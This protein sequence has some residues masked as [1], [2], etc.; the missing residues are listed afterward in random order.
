MK[1]ILR[2]IPAILLGFL[3]MANATRAEQYHYKSGTPAVKQMAAGC[4]PGANFK[5]LEIN[6]VRTRINTGGDMWWDFEVAQY[7]VPKGSKKMSMFSAA[8]WIGGL[9]ANGQLKLAALRYRQVGNDYWPG[10]LTI[11]GTAS[12]SPDVCAKYDKL[13]A[14][15]R[16]EVDDFL[17]WFDDKAAHPD[18][19]PPTSITAYPAHGDE[20][21]GQS[22][23]LAPFYDSD[24]TGDP[25]GIY[26]PEN[27]GDYPYYDLSNELCHTKTL[28]A[29]DIY[30]NKEQTGNLVDQVLKG[31]ATLWW[32]FN[33]KG[34]IHSETKGD[35][36][37]LEIRAQAF[38]F[39]TNDEINNMTFYSYEIINRSTYRLTQTYFSQWVDT[40]LG[41]AKDDYVGCD[42]MRGLG[43]CYNGTAVDGSGQSFAYGNQPPAIGVDFFQGPYIDK[44]KDNKLNGDNPSTKGDPT[45]HLKG[46]PDQ[47]FTGGIQLV[48]WDGDTIEKVV[49]PG[50]TIFKVINSAA[51]NGI[52]FGNDIEDD[53]RFGMRRFVYHNNGGAAY[54][55]DPSVAIE[56]YNYLRGIWK[57]GTKMEYGGNGHITA[58]ATGPE[59]DFM[60]PGTTDI[61]DWGTKGLPPNGPKNWTEVTAGNPPDD[62]RFMESAGP[63]VL[64]P[65]AVNYITVGIP[66]A[67][68]LT[69][70]PLASVKLLQQV[71]DK[72]QQ[73][74]DNCFKVI[75]GPNAPDLTI[76]EMD[77]ELILYISNRKTN[78]A[79][80]NFQEKYTEY[81][82]RIQGSETDHWDSLYRFEGYQIYQLKNATVSVADLKNNEQARLVYQCDVKNNVTQLVNYYFDQNL[83]GSVPVEEV[84]GTDKGVIHSVK[85]S[86]DIFTGEDLINHKQYYYLAVAYAHNNY[87]DYKQSDP[88]SLNGQKLPYLAGRKNIKTYTGIPHTAIGLVSA[89]SEYGDGLVVTRT[90]GQGNGGRFLDLSD[91]SIAEIMSKKM[92]DSTNLPGGPD[93]PIAYNLTYKKDLGPI[94]V[95]VIDPLNVKDGSYTVKFDSMYNVRV[96]VGVMDTTMMAASWSLVDNA[97]GK[98]YVSDTSINTQNEQ[99]FL[100]LGLSVVIEQSLY[101]GPYIVDTKIKQQ[102]GSPDQI[103]P[104]YGPVLAKNGY[105]GGSMVYQDS[106]KPWLNFLPDVDGLPNFDWIRAGLRTDVPADWNN[107]KDM[108][109]DPDAVY[110]SVL[111][112]TWTPYMFAETGKND[113]VCGVAHGEVQ[114]EAQSRERCLFTDISGVDI[115]FTAD[116]SKWTRCAVIELCPFPKASFAEGGAKQFEVRKGKSV[117]Q[118]GDTAVVSSDPA[119]NSE[120]IAANGMSWFPGYAI[121]VET[122][123]RLNI[124]FGE[125]SRMVDDNGRD[126]IFNPSSRRMAPGG[127]PV[128]GGKHFI[129]VMGHIANKKKVVAPSS[130][131]P[132]EA[133]DS[134]AYDGCANFVKQVN[135]PR[136]TALMK[137]V[138]G[139]QF[140]NCMWVSIPIA[141]G[142]NAWLN[143]DLKIKLR[144]TKPYGR[145]FSTPLA[146]TQ[147]GNNYWPMYTFET[148]GVVTNYNDV[149]KAE[150]DLDMIN[151][152]PNPYYAYSKYE[153]NQL[154]NRVKI[155][156]LPQRCTVT[157]YSTN[158]NIVRQYNKDEAKTSIDWDLKN[159]AGIPIAGGVYIIHVKSDQGEKVIKWFGSLRPVDLN[160]F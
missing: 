35:P 1:N 102:T 47:L 90:A 12:I 56:Y 86:K 89:Q 96:K 48:L 157:I 113:T 45:F 52:N 108:A 42:V 85:M 139:L 24:A 51:I 49:S 18:Y 95:K 100:D 134:P 57:D 111:G 55:Q 17:A 81:D 117:N 112:G 129:Y 75:S 40:D 63:F 114:V 43:Y 155:V 124:M 76:R 136:L 127:H 116:K 74:F 4:T 2:I 33:D 27:D 8:L 140:S 94:N 122:G 82:P 31:D 32:V 38:G 144:I 77:Q 67:Q 83:G 160:A 34:N 99:L 65:G 5:W 3:L 150:T 15:T 109:F 14:I 73:L 120:F 91:E 130:T 147:N 59:C 103:L 28:T 23:Y 101:P 118:D 50:D 80:N 135:T 66:W 64:E 132:A 46:S 7:E 106:T 159:F 21:A 158:G 6:N 68:A 88:T 60:F 72:C 128:M 70:G 149:A 141:N 44:D 16:A 123:E 10:P 145:Y 25:N 97:T 30:Y 151:I 131:L 93:Y 152:V 153:A 26:D 125:D 105:L 137:Q 98:V 37:G 58:G 148:K 29:E 142:D 78:D 107:A 41:F 146:G 154:D 22:F 62:R 79:G 54:M 61:Y 71:D 11:D 119:K 87:K 115:V 36:I 53:E 19:R 39:S 20:A 110:E 104:V 13:H 156:N 121:N 133:F 84:V 92:V 69:G 143:S 138:R 9:D 126:M